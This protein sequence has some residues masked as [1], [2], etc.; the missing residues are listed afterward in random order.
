MFA[1]EIKD[2]ETRIAYLESF[3]KP[4]EMKIEVK[5][6]EAERDA[7]NEVNGSL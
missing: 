6:T 3:V 2:Y 4:C 5:L 1:K 7:L